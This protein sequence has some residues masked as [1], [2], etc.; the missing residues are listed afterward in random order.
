M[1]RNHS[2]DI[3]R[4]ATP[5][6]VTWLLKS[7]FGL[8]A[9]L[10]LLACNREPPTV[11]V[12]PRTCG[13]PLWEPEHAGA[14]TVAR[15][16]GFDLYWNAPTQN[17]DVQGQIALMEKAEARGHRALIL[18]PIE[19]FPFQAPVRRLLARGTPVVV[20]DTDLGIAPSRGLTYVMSDEEAGGKWPPVVWVRYSTVKAPWR[21]WESTPGSPVC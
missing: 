17:D 9:A 4:E 7:V 21:C 2:S 1:Y 19:T 13:T 15:S 3:H 16:T 10:P 18:S 12:I 5:C 14:A 11:A 20:I 6:T 8:L